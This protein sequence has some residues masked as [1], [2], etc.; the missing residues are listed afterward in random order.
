MVEPSEGVRAGERVLLPVALGSAGE[1]TPVLR[2]QG[3]ITTSAITQIQ[4][5][6]FL[7]DLNCRPLP[8]LRDKVVILLSLRLLLLS[9][10]VV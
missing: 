1:F 5:Q 7:E 3:T 8:S 6:L 4:S 9:F 10:L 2:I